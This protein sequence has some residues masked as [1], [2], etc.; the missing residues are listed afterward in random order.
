MVVVTKATICKTVAYYYTVDWTCEDEY[1]LRGTIAEQA[2]EKD[3]CY[4]SCGNSCYIYLCT[5]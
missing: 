5:I 4:H 3:G 2:A 1:A